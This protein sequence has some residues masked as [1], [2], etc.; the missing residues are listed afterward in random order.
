MLRVQK[1]PKPKKSKRLRK[2]LSNPFS[3]NESKLK[4]EEK[5]KKEEK[6]KASA[7]RDV[8]SPPFWV[9]LVCGSQTRSLHPKH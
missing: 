9:R 4:T 7:D 3:K 1:K 5:E 2:F 6:E 8:G